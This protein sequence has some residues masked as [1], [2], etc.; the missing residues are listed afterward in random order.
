MYINPIHVPLGPSIFPDFSSCSGPSNFSVHVS[1]VWVVCC[2]EVG[3][4]IL[5]RQDHV[6][7]A[8][9]GALDSVG[10]Q[11]CAAKLRLQLQFLRSMVMVVH[12]SWRCL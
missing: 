9:D 7:A 6:L 2:L 12:P 8:G 4:N 1:A 10:G 11:H 3:G 5:C